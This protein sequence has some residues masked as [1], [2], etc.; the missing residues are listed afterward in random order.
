MSE[1]HLQRDGGSTERVAVHSLHSRD[2]LRVSRTDGSLGSM[3]GRVFLSRR[4]CGGNSIP[5]WI[6]GRCSY[7]ELLRRFMHLGIQRVHERRVSSGPL[8]SRVESFS[9]PVSCGSQLIVGGSEVR[10][11]LSPML[12]GVLL[13]A[14]RDGVGHSRLLAW[15]LLSFGNVEPDGGCFAAVPSGFD[16]SLGK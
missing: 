8:L 13:S 15:L 6:L 14:Q 4:Q 10:D 5:Q 3:L 11:G 12:E 2:V 1:R 9:D 16:V 7:L